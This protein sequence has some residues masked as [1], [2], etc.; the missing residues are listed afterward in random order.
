MLALTGCDVEDVP[1]FAGHLKTPDGECVR[2]VVQRDANVAALQAARAVVAGSTALAHINQAW[3][4]N[5]V[6]LHV[7]KVLR[8]VYEPALL[9]IRVGEALARDA[10]AHRARLMVHT[11]RCL[12]RGI[13]NAVIAG[14]AL[15]VTFIHR[16]GWS[17]SRSRSFGLAWHLAK[18]MRRLAARGKSAAARTRG[19]SSEP[20]SVLLIQED[21]LSLDRSYRSQ[22]HFLFV[23]E[24]KGSLSCRILVLL[25]PK[26]VTR[27]PVD[28]GALAAHGVHLVSEDDV[29]AAGGPVDSETGRRLARDSRRCTLLALF[30]GS[31]ALGLAMA[32]T[33]RLLG[34]ANQL[35]AFCAN[36]NVRV[37]MN[38]EGYILE[39]DAMP[40]AAR[41]VGLHTLAY[42]YS[43]LGGL[44][45]NMV[46][47]ADR[48]LTFASRYDG[49]LCPPDIGPASST[50]IG[51]VF[52]SSFPL[53]R[54][55]AAKWRRRLAAAGARFVICYFD[56]NVQGDRYGF[57][58]PA[59]QQGEI[60]C[61][62]ERLLSDPEL[63]VIVKVQF[64][65]NAPS[66]WHDLDGLLARAR[67]SGRFLELLHGAHR[68]NVFPAEAAMAADV[69]IGHAMGSTASL[70]AAIAGCRSVIINEHG[71][72]SIHDELYA[73]APIVF[74]SLN[75]ALTGIDALR[76][77]VDGAESVGD[78][79]S[80]L[81]TFDEFRDEGT[82]ARM[83]AELER[84]VHGR[85]LAHT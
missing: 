83:R 37:F 12:N 1:F 79:S 80:I 49:R 9:R 42:Q 11:P 41:V 59:D 39:A 43:N 71:A 65:R 28:A 24:P 8:S 72:R 34:R 26:E 40:I 76:R 75:A 31:S 5:T 82:A 73:R 57:V 33:A 53:L 13:L 20:P 67:E 4:R 70:E 6:L 45:V 3:G 56:E 47:T 68:N 44:S 36:S 10:G 2:F 19:P 29:L 69:A 7:A 21:D 18:A 22:P 78:W 16:T 66:E 84:A 15:H 17:L 64:R 61:L 58:A 62:L 81:G 48:V 50:P 55:R 38:C 51:Y 23:G 60:A 27:M 30:A 35:A 25:K 46:T 14:A 54:P 63:G 85:D 32:R 77:G 52:S 74:P